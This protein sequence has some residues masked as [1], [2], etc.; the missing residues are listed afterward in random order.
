[1]FIVPALCKDAV[2]RCDWDWD[3]TVVAT[4]VLCGNVVV[5]CTV[6]VEGDWVDWLVV[7]SRILESTEEVGA[8]A[9]S[10]DVRNGLV[11]MME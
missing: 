11:V 3:K 9:V 7:S 1:M 5:A 8:D 10:D 2:G 4:V 6:E